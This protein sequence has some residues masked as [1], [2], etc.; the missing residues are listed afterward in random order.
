MKAAEP[1]IMRSA[2]KRVV[3]KNAAS[4]KVS[5]LTDRV[6]VMHQGIIVGLGALDD[7]LARPTHPYVRGLRDDYVLRTGPIGLPPS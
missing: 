2:Q 1:V 3:H 4:R 5:R 7:V 6:A